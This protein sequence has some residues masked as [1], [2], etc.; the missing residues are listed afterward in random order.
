MEYRAIFER[1]NHVD[2]ITEIAKKICE[3]YQIGEY[4]KHKIIEIGYEDFNVVLDTTYD[5]YFV[6]ILN[7]DRTDEECKRLAKIYDV[8][9]N[10]GIHV[11]M[12][13]KNNNELLSEI[14]EKD[15]KLRILLMEY[16]TGSNMYELGRN[17]TL[18]EIKQVANQATKINQIDF[19]VNSYYDEWT[20]TNFKREYE[21]KYHLICEEDKDIVNRCYQEFIKLDLEALPKAY[22][23]GDIMNA[24]LIKGQEK[25]WLIDF[26]VLNYLPRIIELVVIAYGICIYDNREDSIYRLNYFLNQYHQQNKITQLELDVFNTMLNAVGAMNIMQT[27]YI[28]A[29][30]GNFEENQYWLDKGKQVIDLD[31]QKEEIR[32]SNLA[33]KRRF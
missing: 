21:R 9:R 29:N 27:S 26:S 12:I 19:K 22:I 32:L 24:N 7:K 25:V 30:N 18:E 23:H 11:P 10:N 1:I 5:R 6:K 16:I 31:L 3:I 15:T 17:L 14:R 4:V 28:K 13:Y 2:N 20:L 8:A 33:K